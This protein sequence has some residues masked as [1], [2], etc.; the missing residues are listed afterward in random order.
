M[1]PKPRNPENRDLP[2]NLYSQ[3]NR[4]SGQT[5][6]RY[7]GPDGRMFGLG[8][9][10]EAAITQAK[11]ANAKHKRQPDLKDRIAQRQGESA[12]ETLERELFD[13]MRAREWADTNF[14]RFIYAPEHV[15]A[16]AEPFPGPARKEAH[17]CCVYVLLRGDRI[18]YVG[19]TAQALEYRLSAHADNGKRFDRVWWVDGLPREMLDDMEDFYM[20]WLKPSENIRPASPGLFLSSKHLAKHTGGAGNVSE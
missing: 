8:T 14:H 18:T 1:S 19:Q 3:R 13:G 12:A 7:R 17:D 20:Q 9:D 5:Y 16:N 6:Y 11:R 4:R 15:I 2:A 10:R